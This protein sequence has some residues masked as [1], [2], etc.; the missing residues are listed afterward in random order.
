VLGP[1]STVRLIRGIDSRQA[2]FLEAIGLGL[3]TVD[4]VYRRLA[5]TL[6]GL[7]PALRP[8]VL[9]DAWAVVD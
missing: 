3:D 2:A 9:A 6:R 8:L 4:L 1:F 7:D 5:A